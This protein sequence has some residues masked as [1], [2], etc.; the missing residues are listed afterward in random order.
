MRGIDDLLYNRSP[1]A[2]HYVVS[3]A[4][5][6]VSLAYIRAEIGQIDQREEI[7]TFEKSH[8]IVSLHQKPNW[9]SWVCNDIILKFN[10]KSLVLKKMLL[11][12]SFVF[13]VFT[14]GAVCSLQHDSKFI[15]NYFRATYVRTLNKYRFIII[16]RSYYCC[17]WWAWISHRWQYVSNAGTSFLQ[18]IKVVRSRLRRYNTEIILL[19]PASSSRSHL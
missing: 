11:K 7:N 18:R 13:T 4:A 15:F 10:A 12:I 8:S 6:A 19:R 1:V 3:S 5:C 16:F 14:I 9:G 17:W 2:H